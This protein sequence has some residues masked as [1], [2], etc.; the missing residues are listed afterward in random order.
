MLI[1]DERGT[2]RPR[3][4]AIVTYPW[5]FNRL[6]CPATSRAD[7]FV[8]EAAAAAFYLLLPPEDA[9][10]KKYGSIADYF[11][12]AEIRKAP[13]CLIQLVTVAQMFLVRSS[14]ISAFIP[15]LYRYIVIISV[16]STKI[17]TF[18]FLCPSLLKENKYNL[19]KLQFK[20]MNVG[21]NSYLYIMY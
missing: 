2:C 14:F 9:V 21:K 3:S 16:I 4:L 11:M 15:V 10:E 6:L 1:L 17:S 18:F 5:K 19:V 7:L 12:R 13:W 8:L 20:F